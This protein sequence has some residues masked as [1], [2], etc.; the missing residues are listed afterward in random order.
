LNG[1]CCGMSVRMEVDRQRE[2][3]IP[4][5]E[6]IRYDARI[7]FGVDQQRRESMPKVM[8]PDAV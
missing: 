1:G 8:D 2:R 7:R 5:S 6:K 3:D 4:M